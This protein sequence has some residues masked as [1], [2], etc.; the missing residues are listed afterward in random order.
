[1]IL[2]KIHMCRYIYTC[3]NIHA[4]MYTQ[5]RTVCYD[6]TSNQFVIAPLS[7]WSKGVLQCVAVCVAACVVLCCSA[8]LYYLDDNM[9]RPHICVI[10]CVV[11]ICSVLYCVAVLHST[12]L[13]AT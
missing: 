7:C 12:I 11:L 6:I 5:R 13:M 10:V 3:L 2:R 4:Y 9:N 1:M 8:S